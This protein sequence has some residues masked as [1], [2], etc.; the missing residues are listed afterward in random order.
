LTY[1]SHVSAQVR[2]APRCHAG[3]GPVLD[4]GIMAAGASWGQR[5]ADRRWASVLL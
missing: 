4:E 2:A 5:P 1:A 3:G